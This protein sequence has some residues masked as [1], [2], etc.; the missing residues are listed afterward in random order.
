MFILV[1]LTAAGFS[2]IVYSKIA[3]VDAKREDQTVFQMIEL[4][5]LVTLVGSFLSHWLY[6]SL[7]GKFNDTELYGIAAMSAGGTVFVA[8]S[9]WFSFRQVE[10]DKAK[11][12]GLYGLRGVVIKAED[13]NA[14]KV[15][16]FREN[17][18]IKLNA[19]SYGSYFNAGDHVIVESAPDHKTVIVK[20]L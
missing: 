1:L 15:T 5:G 3:R 7:M 6:M 19:M 16:L 20:A 13:G 10:K 17:D 8:S 14:K 11:T 18:A 4:M 12:R 9:V 2:F